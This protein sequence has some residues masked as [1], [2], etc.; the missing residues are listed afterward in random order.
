VSVRGPRR[1]YLSAA[2]EEGRSEG[3]AAGL[4]AAREQLAVEASAVAR[5]LSRR[6]PLGQVCAAALTEYVVGL[7]D[8]GEDVDVDGDGPSMSSLLK[9]DR[10]IRRQP[11]PI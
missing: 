4:R 11:A 6:G 5:V 7:L 1:G 3:Y 9:I 8:D 10:G 2:R